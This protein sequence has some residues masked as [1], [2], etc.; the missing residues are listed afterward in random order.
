MFQRIFFLVVVIVVSVAFGV[1]VERDYRDEKIVELTAERDSARLRAD[2][3][4]ILGEKSVAY[5]EQAIDGWNKANALAQRCA[6]DL[7]E[8]ADALD[9]CVYRGARGRK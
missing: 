1:T 5:G 2:A 3:L 4:F 8:T 6:D 7:D 9:R